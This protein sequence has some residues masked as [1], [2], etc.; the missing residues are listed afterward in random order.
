[1]RPHKNPQILVTFES[2]R[3]SLVSSRLVQMIN[4][5]LDL[6]KLAQINWVDMS[7]HLPSNLMDLPLDFA[8]YMLDLIHNSSPPNLPPKVWTGPRTH[9]FRSELKSGHHHCLENIGHIQVTFSWCLQDGRRDENHMTAFQ[10]LEDTLACLA[11]T[12]LNLV[13]PF[14]AWPSRPNSPGLLSSSCSAAWWF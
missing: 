14:L 8:S 12:Y 5:H 9:F 11:A 10:G 13:K 3:K 6:A 1:M 2:W 4:A 7:R